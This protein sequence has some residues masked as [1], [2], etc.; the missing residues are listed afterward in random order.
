MTRG[1]T[2]LE[3]TFTSSVSE[4]ALVRGYG[5]PELSITR[6]AS[7]DGRPRHTQERAYRPFFV[8]VPPAEYSV[9]RRLFRPCACGTF[10]GALPDDHE[11][12]EEGLTEHHLSPA[13]VDWRQREGL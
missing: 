1:I 11:D 7:V 10:V 5:V 6:L 8:A 4:E 13:H 9:G 12:I 3:H 2:D